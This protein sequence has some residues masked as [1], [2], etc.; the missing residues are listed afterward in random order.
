MA[1]GGFPSFKGAPDNQATQLTYETTEGGVQWELAGSMPHTAA[2]FSQLYLVSSTV[3]YATAGQV[4]ER[5]NGPGYQ[6]LYQTTN[7]GRTWTMVLSA[8]IASVAVTSPTTVDASTG[9][10][11]WQRLNSGSTWQPL[12]QSLF[13]ADWAETFPMDPSQVWAV[14]STRMSHLL[15]DT[16][17]AGR[18]WTT[19][20]TL[21]QNTL[22]NW[23]ARGG[24]VLETG[25]AALVAVNGFQTRPIPLPSGA[26]GFTAAAFT[27][28]R[29][30]WLL[31]SSTYGPAS[32]YRTDSGG[33]AWTPIPVPNTNGSVL[34]LRGSDMAVLGTD[35]AVS[36]DGGR[37]WSKHILRGTGI[38]LDSAAWNN[39]T[40]WVF[41]TRGTTPTPLARTWS[42]GKWLRHPVNVALQSV[43]L[44]GTQGW[45]ASV[46]GSLYHSTDGGAAWHRVPVNV[47]SPNC[48]HRAVARGR[49]GAD[50]PGSGDYTPA[51]PTYGRLT[52]E[53]ARRV[54][55]GSR[56][57]HVIL[58]RDD[59]ESLW[60]FSVPTL[61]GCFT[62]TAVDESWPE[63]V[64]PARSIWRHWRKLATPPL[65][66]MPS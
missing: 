19:L 22:V 53:E 25:Q 32:L 52:P 35:V 38:I 56:R 43:S 33:A 59:D 57:C 45:A 30:G 13:G 37:H 18:T 31:A 16:C 63:P 15:I 64:R 20:L 47:I 51:P 17:N 40:L 58:H 26:S 49:V 54:R 3:A 12:Q 4:P 9:G 34:A 28:P 7:G 62:P 29:Q 1:I 8:R 65:K 46:N 42:Q 55:T 61:P 5:A 11:T 44:A 39:G 41:G 48:Y 36:T 14:V 21:G 50:G 23:F 6:A 24:G 2:S 60:W 10:V 66:T 27:S